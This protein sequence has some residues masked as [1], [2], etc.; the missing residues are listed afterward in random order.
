MALNEPNDARIRTVQRLRA[1]L[2]CLGIEDVHALDRVSERIL[3]A[4][5]AVE[6][7][8]AFESAVMDEV[9]RLEDA[10]IRGL[11]ESS[12]AC[13]TAQEADP[14]AGWR[15]RSVLRKHPEAL[16]QSPDPIL[17]DGKAESWERCCTPEIREIRMQHQ[18]LGKMPIGLRKEFWRSIGR[19]MRSI[20]PKR[21]RPT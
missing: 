6:D 14:F 9:F 10:W 7:D 17:L 21:S 2:R 19:R 5:E 11:S 1:F 13:K 12:G 3:Q 15:L 4:A 20:W 8:S 18:P 16:L